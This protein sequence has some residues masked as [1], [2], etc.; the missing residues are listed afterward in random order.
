MTPLAYDFKK[1]RAIKKRRKKGKGMKGKQLE[2]F[3]NE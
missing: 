3:E 2:L 1:G